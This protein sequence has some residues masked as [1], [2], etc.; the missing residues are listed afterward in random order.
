[1]LYEVITDL[2][3]KRGVK[4]ERTYQLNTGGNTDFLNML[5][6]DRL[7][8]K[9]ISKTEAV[10]SVLAE[11]LENGNIHVG[12]SDYVSWQKDNKVCS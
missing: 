3:R 2:F 9:K 11:R 5:N 7:A 6:R 8:S 1:M 4:L 10:Q 12:P